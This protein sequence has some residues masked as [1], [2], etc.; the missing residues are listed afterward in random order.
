[1]QG[2]GKSGA[3]LFGRAVGRYS[4][5]LTKHVGFRFVHHV[6]PPGRGGTPAGKNRLVLVHDRILTVCAGAKTTQYRFDALAYSYRRRSITGVGTGF[7]PGQWVKAVQ[8]CQGSGKRQAEGYA[9]R[10]SRPCVAPRAGGIVRDCACC[11]H[12][13]GRKPGAGLDGSER[14]RGL[15]GLVM[16]RF[17]LRKPAGHAS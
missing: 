10:Q 17:G 1:M 9:A 3:F 15:F 14:D 6:Q 7:D 12:H 13:A 4:A 8:N 2:M 11:P 5:H 16:T